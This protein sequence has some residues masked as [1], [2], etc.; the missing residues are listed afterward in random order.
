MDGVRF[1]LVYAA[2]VGHENNSSCSAHFWQ[3]KHVGS[4]S[5]QREP[6]MRRM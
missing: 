4:K 3:H 6:H 5:G 1:D 2:R